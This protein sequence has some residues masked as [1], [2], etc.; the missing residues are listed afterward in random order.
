MD[1]TDLLV[2]LAG[3]ICDAGWM[4]LQ[5]AWA[6]GELILVGPE[7]DFLEVGIAV[8]QDDVANVQTWMQSDQLRP[9]KD[10]EARAFHDRRTQFR[11]LI[12]PP[13]VFVQALT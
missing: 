10:E 2:K 4:D 11:M 1:H 9:V 12:L 5:R 8:A 7:L 6:K 13:H 3:E